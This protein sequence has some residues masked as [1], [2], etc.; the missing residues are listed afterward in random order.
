[1]IKNEDFY[2]SIA[3]SLAKKWYWKTWS[4]PLV[5]AVVVK[6]NIVIWKAYHEEF[7]RAHAEVKAIT[8]VDDIEDLHW[9]SLFVTL[10]PCNHTGKTPPCS[11]L[12]I[13]SWIKKVY[14]GSLD[15]NTEASWWVK[16]LKQAWIKVE[17]WILENECMKIN[18]E[19]FKIHKDKNV[20]VIAKTASS[21]DWAIALSN[22]KS[23]WITN[24]KARRDWRKLRWE[25]DAII[26]W[27]NTVIAD[28]PLLTARS[29]WLK[30]PV[31]VILD[32]SLRIWK[33]A[34]V[35]NQDAKT[36]I[37][38][39]ENLNWNDFKFQSKKW[40]YIHEIIKQKW[41]KICPWELLKVLYDKWLKKILIEWW[42]TVLSSFFREWFV[43]KLISYQS[44]II[45]GWD[46][47]SML[48]NLSLTSLS[49]A[50]KLELVKSKKMWD[51]L[52]R[53]YNI[54][55]DD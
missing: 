48:W 39:S 21:L 51:N 15:P 26:V 43:D 35:L 50:C 38:C 5:W 29:K 36:I 9:A 7:W 44:P 30:N 13:K 41:D 2:M 40:Q 42:P 52:R 10:E 31:R 22:W 4:N 37:F 34:K 11:D 17:I 1:M 55:K 33:N 16:T 14:I 49:R 54:I 32:S 53:D 19:F 20:Y 24:E 46:A 27:I 47:K 28:D 3:I 45:L 25:V 18:N 12:I 8:S 6:D 23:K